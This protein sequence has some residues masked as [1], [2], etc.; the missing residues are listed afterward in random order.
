VRTA[1]RAAAALVLLTAS[2]ALANGRYPASNQIVFSPTRANLV[3]LRTTFG[4]LLSHDDAATWTWL[5]EG[6][7]GIAPSA[8][9]DPSLGLTAGDA[10]IAGLYRG[11][12]V[13]NDT[14]C[15][16]SFVPSLVNQHAVDVSV[17]SAAPHSAV[18]LVSTYSS[19]TVADSSMGYVTQLYETA[20]DGATWVALG[21]PFDPTVSVTT[22]DV[23]ASDP[24]RLY[25]TGFRSSTLFT[26]VLFVS[27]DRGA[28]WSE[29]AMPQLSHDLG[30]YIA[31]V[32][33]ANADLVYLRTAGAPNP[34]GRSRLFVTQ[35]Q[36]RSFQTLLSLPGSMLGF[37]L[38]PDGSKVYAGIEKGGLFVA[39]RNALEAVPDGGGS[40]AAVGDAGGLAFLAFRQTSS[41]HVQCLA[42]HGAQLWA[43]SDEASGFVAGVS[44]DDGATFTPK[45]HKNGVAAPIGCAADA[46]AA[47][48]SGPPFQQ[49]CQLLKGCADG[50]DVEAGASD[51]GDDATSD[52]SAPDAASEAPDEDAGPSASGSS[53]GCSTVGGG[54]AAGL[55]AAI[56]AAAA[57]WRRRHTRWRRRRTRATPVARA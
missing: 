1:P 52:A 39:P 24:N 28:S 13:S 29:H 14:G 31:A 4:V 42:T 6:A 53:C 15:D 56:A 57:A 27:V 2:T 12:E 35:D 48:C 9:E 10:L 32:D 3:V 5:C 7:L 18:A 22:I 49:L 8:S 54:R 23:A 40:L 43:C 26:P 47:Q 16:W 19:T 45:L 36:G 21:G 33:P 41:I 44:L 46:T 25:V 11:L 20:D 50:G 37:A 30:V 51:A 38:S 17:R 34:S 55:M